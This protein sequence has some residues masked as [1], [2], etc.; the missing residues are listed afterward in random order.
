[1]IA[2]GIGYI[3]NNSRWASRV[4]PVKKRDD[5]MTHAT[6]NEYG[7]FSKPLK[8]DELILKSY[9][10]T[11]DYVV[12]NSICV[13]LAGQM[14]FQDVA[15]ESAAG[16]KYHGIFDFVSGFNQIFME[17]LSAEILS[18]RT[19]LGIVTKNRM[20]M[21]HVDSAL[22]FQSCV[23]ETLRSML[24]THCAVWIDDV[25]VYAKTA[26]E[27]AD[28]LGQ[29]FD[30][31]EDKDWKLSLKKSKLFSEEIKWCGRIITAEGIKHDPTRIQA[32]CD[33]QYPETAGDLMQ[34]LCA[35]G[36]MRSSIVDFARLSKPLNEKLVDATSG[37]KKTKR[38]AN[39]VKIV[40]D[41]SD[42]QHFD[43]L[44]ESV[45][46]SVTLA[47]PK[48]GAKMCMFTDASD[49]GWAIIVT[50][51]LQWD[52]KKLAHEQDHQMLHCQSGTFNG[53]QLNWS[54]VEKECYPVSK[55]CSTL[56]HLLMRPDGFTIY[57]DH[58]NLVHMFA[59]AQD[60]KKHIRGKL[61]RWG[62]QLQQYRYKLEHVA[63]ETNVV[64]N[65]FSRWGG[66]TMVK[67]NVVMES[68][69]LPPM[70]T[71]VKLSAKQ[72]RQLRKHMKRFTRQN[73]R[74]HQQSNSKVQ[75]MYNIRVSVDSSEIR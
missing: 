14:P 34:F 10:E 51:V 57:C 37:K 71:P 39:G 5:D 9:R 65:M 58:R 61:L 15:L 36:W 28:V 3:N 50:Q 59:P 19:P 7:K 32:L 72:D 20:P 74:D 12:V 8:P 47:F 62:L 73:N 17:A 64:A 25:I 54:I 31:L 44:K 29:M 67:S 33:M 69:A 41:T 21:G 56:D 52:N 48:P 24:G 75:F 27:Y 43:A 23:E 26:K 6:K 60:V 2:D 42:K 30:L 66:P 38:V 49:L 1:M 68:V 70:K 16:C 45:M 55:A 46:K 53:A 35:A 18:S 63:G 11:V 4:L 40:M 22:Y 13:P